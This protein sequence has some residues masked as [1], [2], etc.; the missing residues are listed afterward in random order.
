MADLSSAP[1][2]F[3]GRL[4]T[5]L[6]SGASEQGVLDQLGWTDEFRAALPTYEVV[7]RRRIGNV[8]LFFEL[9]GPSEA[10]TKAQQLDVIASTL[11][12]ERRWRPLGLS[13]RQD[14]TVATLQHAS[15][16]LWFWSQQRCHIVGSW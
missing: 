3:A 2:P 1:P 14:E 4:L 9:L 6:Q 5:R 7:G 15:L 13:S 16:W 10:A 12:D 11:V 8:G